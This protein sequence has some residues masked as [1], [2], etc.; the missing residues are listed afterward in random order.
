MSTRGT[1]AVVRVRWLTAF[2]DDSAASFDTM[3]DFWAEVTMSTVSARRGETAQFVTLIPADGDACLRAQRI[4]EG[5]GGIHLDLHT[6]DIDVGVDHAVRLGA[7]VLAE[8]GYVVM[9]SPGGFVFCVVGHHAEQARPEPV[10]TPPS[11]VDQ[12]C[13]DIPLNLYQVECTFWSELIQWELR[14]SG[15]DEFRS[16]AR[17]AG[18]PLRLLLQRLGAD[19]ERTNVHAH[20]DLAC[21]A[22]HG[23]HA[24]WH[25]RLG[26][27]TL[28]SRPFWTTMTDPAGLRYCLTSR[29]PVT[30]LL[31]G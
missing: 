18:M 25:E 4:D 24:Q 10:G 9:A 5:P 30:G 21:G 6:D 2:L 14:L 11:L 8:R 15:S 3:V 19:D 22:H 20:L 1:V 28:G 16:L 26:A 12:I 31:T 23:E 7:T 17:P 27:L 29:D 13:L